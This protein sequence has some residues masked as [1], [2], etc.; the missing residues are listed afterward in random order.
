MLIWYVDVNGSEERKAV[1]ESLAESHQVTLKL[2]SN[3]INIVKDVHSLLVHLSTALNKPQPF[4]WS[5]SVGMRIRLIPQKSIL[6]MSS[7]VF[8]PQIDPGKRFWPC[9]ARH[10]EGQVVNLVAKL[11]R[12]LPKASLGEG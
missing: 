3:L 7:W 9:I 8:V 1:R 11:G 12:E 6:Y 4:C 5:C 10:G 2:E